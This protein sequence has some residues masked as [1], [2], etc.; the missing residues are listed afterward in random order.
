MQI[1]YE[2]S[3]DDSSLDESGIESFLRTMKS[4]EV[5]DS[6]FKFTTEEV[7]VMFP[8]KPYQCQI[9]FM[10]KLINSLKLGDNALLES[11][12]G[13]G[14]T[15]SLL[16]ASLAW[17]KNEREKNGRFPPSLTDKKDYI[18]IIYTSRTHSQLSQVQREL[19]NTAYNPRS[20]LLASRDHMCVHAEFKNLNIEEMCKLG[21]EMVIC[22]YFGNKDRA[23]GAD[24]LFMPYNF[25]IDPKI[26]EIFEFKFKNSIIIFDEAH[27]V[28]QQA[29]DA[30]SFD[31]D[32]KQ[33][34]YVVN[35]LQKLE[36][37]RL[38]RLDFNFNSKS[39]DTI[40]LIQMLKKLKSYIDN[41]ELNQN[42]VKGFNINK[43]YINVASLVMP[44]RYI[45]DIIFNGTLINDQ[46]VENE[47]SFEI[48]LETDW[49]RWKQAIE[50]CLLDITQLQYIE[51]RTSLETLFEILKKIMN[52]HQNG[53]L[54]EKNEELKQQQY[55]E[56]DADDYY[57]YL[58]DEED[59]ANKQMQFNKKYKPKQFM[60]RTSK[61]ILAFWC[62][63]AGICFRE[64]QKLEPKSIILTSGTLTPMNSF[65]AEL[66]LKFNQ[67]IENPHVIST[68]Q[69]SIS[70]LTKGIKQNC[71]NFSYQYRENEKAL[72]DLGV[73][74]AQ[75]SGI[76]P[77][78]I[79]VFFP[80]YR[81][82]RRCYELWE[83]NKPRE[84][85]NYKN[86]MDGYY[87]SIFEK[88]DDSLNGGILLSV[89]RGRIS[90]GLDF[91]DNA[92]R[93][94][95]IVGIPFPLLTDPKVILKR[96][97]LDRKLQ[98]NN[99]DLV[100]LSGKDWYNQC[101][102]RAVNQAIGRNFY[103]LMKKQGFK[104]KVDQLAQ[105]KIELMDENIKRIIQKSKSQKR[106]KPKKDD[107]SKPEVDI[108]ELPQKPKRQSTRVRIQKDSVNKR[109]IKNSDSTARNSIK[110]RTIDEIES[111]G[112]YKP[113]QQTQKQKKKPQESTD[114][115][116]SPEKLYKPGKLFNLSRVKPKN[117]AETKVQ[118]Q[119]PNTKFT[120]SKSNNQSDQ[121][122][123]EQEHSDGEVD[124]DY[125]FQFSMSDNEKQ[126]SAT[127][128]PISLNDHSNNPNSTINYNKKESSGQENSLQNKKFKYKKQKTYRKQDQRVNRAFEKDF[129]NFELKIGKIIA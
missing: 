79:L 61:R 55:N 88:T 58:Y 14:K 39:E 49:T 62:F 94:V 56:N 125:N 22:P 108:N 17:L 7:E 117:Q 2:N 21:E 30:S 74:I 47:E 91:S 71:F 65:Q 68:D 126:K 98:Q 86:V 45:F 33:L 1:G 11:P 52:L 87:R 110:K 72:I 121:S 5:I 3:D 107:Q 67:R 120:I 26:R 6:Q 32:T 59:D 35:E 69:V 81:Y 78:G 127:K 20:L 93:C 63:N 40:S 122:C 101:G 36:D 37:E 18:Q 8:F 54:S 73:S 23:A 75:I 109:Y 113:N 29:E 70:V 96:D 129:Q 48:N 25:L 16:C 111:D 123:S 97:Y 114:E 106:P 53:P 84:L 46:S 51:T 24:I 9:N 64:L 57:V 13:T 38:V 100:R 50:N 43:Q 19:K 99:S 105:I 119:A 95:I 112:E 10:A 118:T 41:Y 92:A 15:L 60:Q 102:I 124:D 44:G 76:T 82:M 128:S 103:D 83:Q 12:T 66:Q 104:A 85:S 115:T 77:G 90:E 42:N 34:E 28:P 116:S 27:N 4:Q 89:C 31:L 80:S